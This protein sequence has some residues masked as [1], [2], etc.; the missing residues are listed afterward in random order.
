MRIVAL[1]L[2]LVATPALA[3]SV[4]EQANALMI[5]STQSAGFSEEVSTEI[6]TCF[7]SRMTDAEATAFIAAADLA[8]QQV[9]VAEMADNPTALACAAEAM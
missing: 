9:V 3:Q 4:Q 5:A 2:P 6:A 7:T 8:A 1:I